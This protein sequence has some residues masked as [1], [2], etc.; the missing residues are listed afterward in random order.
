[1]RARLLSV[2]MALMMSAALGMR[3]DAAD[4]EIKVTDVRQLAGTWKG[5]GQA[6]NSPANGMDVVIDERG[7]AQNVVRPAGAGQTITGSGEFKIED[8]KLLY[9][10]QSSK[11]Q[12]TL[13]EKNG[14]RV[15]SGEGRVK[16]DGRDA[17]T[18][19]T[20]VK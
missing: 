18:E 14:K 3:T 10:S 1:M 19:L 13:R 17:W 11:L 15:L 5:V 2:F 7:K 6:G 16:A 9:E 8:G 20:E 12:Y 4:G